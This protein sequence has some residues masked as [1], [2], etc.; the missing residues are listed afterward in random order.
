MK[1]GH[2]EKDTLYESS[3][4]RLSGTM[5]F[6][7]PEQFEITCAACMKNHVELTI[8]SFNRIKLQ[9]QDCGF[10]EVG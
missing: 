10:E 6:I 2:I 9:C 5:I 7:I 4:L 8:V 1:E 3:L